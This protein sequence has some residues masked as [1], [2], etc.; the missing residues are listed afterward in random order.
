MRLAPFLL[1]LLL[2]CAHVARAWPPGGVRFERAEQPGAN[3]FQGLGSDGAG[4]TYTAW[5]ERDTTGAYAF[6]VHRLNV[7]GDP[8]AGWTTAG[9]HALSPAG[10]TFMPLLVPDGVGGTYVAW[11]EGDSAAYVGHLSADGSLASGWPARGLPV[12]SVGRQADLE[13][14]D[15]GAG[16]VLVAW[17]R[18]GSGQSP[19]II[20]Q[21]FLAD[22]TRAPGFPAQGRALTVYHYQRGR[23]RLRLL[24]D[25]D[26]GFWVS[27]H[28]VTIDPVFAPS[29]YAVLRLDSSGLLKAGQ[30]TNGWSLSVPD[31]E[32]GTL[33]PYAP[34]ALAP[35]GTGGTF[36]FTL[37]ADGT[38]RAFHVLSSVVEDPSWPE[39]GV[40][41]GSGASWPSGHFFF[42]EENW[43]V[44]TGDLSGGAWVG[45]RDAV[46]F[47]L[48]VGRVEI[49][50][51]IAP[52]W[53][54]PPP[55]AGDMTVTLLGDPAGLYAASLAPVSCPHFDCYGP[56]SLVRM[57]VDGSLA[58]GW[59]EADPPYKPAPGIVLGYGGP[60]N[61]PRLIAD[62][63]GGVV[64]AW[65]E[66]PEYHAMRFTIAGQLAGVSPAAGRVGLRARFDRAAG[67]RVWYSTG[68]AASGRIELFDVTGRRVASVSAEAGGGEIALAGTR[69]LGAGVFLARITT[70]VGTAATKLVALP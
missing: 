15:D 54:S 51:T 10:F 53:A 47:L 1:V 20:T 41:I 70:E 43:P 46:D 69:S 38:V 2:V 11:T 37:G 30:P 3:G 19:E 6:R 13:A 67:V 34:V 27:F 56:M 33:Q 59:P 18:T 65:V 9:V 24:R 66:Y 22:G 63:A 29:A 55:I 52:S 12:S 49:D 60:Q 5:V 21:R 25:A 48:H 32:I 23:F 68:S 62:G 26:R 4:G 61:G 8:P 35:D 42:D 44:A 58:P 40:V 64:A 45:W 7:Q 17:R 14:T 31:A 39:G 36:A 50:G 16:G 57:N 28:T